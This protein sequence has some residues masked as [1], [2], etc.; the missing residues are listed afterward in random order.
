MDTAG[1]WVKYAIS[2]NA[3]GQYDLSACLGAADAG[4]TFQVIVDSKD[5]YEI[6]VPAEGMTEQL[7]AQLE[8]TAGNHT[9]KVRLRQG[10]LQ[11]SSFTL[12]AAAA[13]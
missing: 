12:T 7:L 6:T 11:V 4:T 1:D 2:V 8:L 13:E 9:L 10:S 3:D 5:I